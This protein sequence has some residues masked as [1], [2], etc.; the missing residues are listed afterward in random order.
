MYV[1]NAKDWQ[2]V[3]EMPNSSNN[4]HSKKRKTNKILRGD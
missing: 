4:N 1:L 3:I 2:G